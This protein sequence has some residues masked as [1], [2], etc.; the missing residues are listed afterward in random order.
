MDNVIKF[1]LIIILVILT[2][3]ATSFGVANIAFKQAEVRVKSWQAIGYIGNAQDYRQALRYADDALFYHPGHNQYLEIK[4]QILEWGADDNMV[5]RQTALQH[6]KQ[7][8]LQSTS[9]R[10]T[11]PATWAALAMLKWRMQEF[12]SQMVSFLQ[13][14]YAMGRN[15]PEVKLAFQQLGPVLRDYHPQLFAPLEPQYD[16]LLKIK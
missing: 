2:I 11:W 4:A 13:N 6:A 5:D 14:A 3:V 15:S 10:P 7:L 1:I 16:D 9:T 8:Y 12:D